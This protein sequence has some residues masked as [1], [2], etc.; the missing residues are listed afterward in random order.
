M[1]LLLLGATGRVGHRFLELASRTDHR[2]TALVRDA[3]RLPK[4]L[5]PRV[6]VLTGNVLEPGLVQRTLHDERYDAVVNVLGGG[7]ARSSLVTDSTRLA[8]EAM[9][10]EGVSRYA[11][12]SVLTLMPATV[13]GRVTAAVLGSTFLRHVDHDHHG[14]LEALRQS[15][16]DWVMV[17]CGKIDDGPGGAPLTRA[18]RFPGGYRAIDTGDVA[19]E[20]WRELETPEHH[21]AAVGVWA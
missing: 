20:L 5:G 17:A 10:T 18:E 4:G 12:I 15:D 11:G 9:R 3:S 2:V 21:R 8:A 14:A 13:P 7:L 16:L 1:N 6:R 19:R